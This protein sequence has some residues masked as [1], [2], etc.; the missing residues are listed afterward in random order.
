MFK[1]LRTSLAISGFLC[2]ITSASTS[3]N[4]WTWDQLVYGSNGDIAHYQT[5]NPKECSHLVAIVG[6]KAEE[7]HLECCIPEADPIVF[8]RKRAERLAL[9][10]LNPAYNDEE[11]R[12]MSQAIYELGNSGK[13]IGE[14]K[15]SAIASSILVDPLT[16]IWLKR[17][18]AEAIHIVY[19]KKQMLS[20]MTPEEQQLFAA[21]QNV[22]HL[23][24]AASYQPPCS[25]AERERRSEDLSTAMRTVSDLE[26]RRADVILR[27][28]YSSLAIASAGWL[29]VNYYRHSFGEYGSIIS[30]MVPIPL[31]CFIEH[32][33]GR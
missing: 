24:A 29:F 8:T 2:L 3:V 1:F 13:R 20:K 15:D 31:Y 4:D 18:I 9:Q 6:R 33:K 26:K 5:F 21:Q 19:L 22:S 10:G 11:Y 25:V 7:V 12:A 32:M 28:K 17:Q 16:Y 14:T 30:M 27:S 23:M